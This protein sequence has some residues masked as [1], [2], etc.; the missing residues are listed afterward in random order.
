LRTRARPA[1]ETRPLAVERCVPHRAE[2]SYQEKRRP[3][4]FRGA[5]AVAQ[6]VPNCAEALPQGVTP[7]RR[8]DQVR[9]MLDPVPPLV[10][11]A[12]RRDPLEEPRPYANP[13]CGTHCSTG[14]GREHTLSMPCDIPAAFLR[15]HKNPNTHQPTNPPTQ[16]P[17]H[18]PTH[19]PK[20]PP[21]HQP[22]HPTGSLRPGRII[23]LRRPLNALH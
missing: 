18:P 12:E 14:R 15:E 10:T 20:H 17:K 16:K 13:Q 19:Q 7:L 5:P 1:P 8:R 6:F 2:A 22:K 4:R 23:Q 3:R 21:P 11:P 9:E